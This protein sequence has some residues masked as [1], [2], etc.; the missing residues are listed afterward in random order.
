MKA[1]EFFLVCLEINGKKLTI[2]TKAEIRSEKP[3]LKKLIPGLQ[4]MAKEPEICLER[5]TSKGILDK[6]LK[7]VEKGI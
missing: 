7:Y 6:T 2:G 1:S 5:G 4:I 3:L